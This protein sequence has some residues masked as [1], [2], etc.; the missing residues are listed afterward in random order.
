MQMLLRLLESTNLPVTYHHWEEE[1]ALP[2]IVYLASGTDNFGADNKVY[3]GITNYNVE[4]YTSKKD[5][6]SEQK[7]ENALNSNDIFWDKSEVYIEAEKMYKVT[8]SIQI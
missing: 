3:T 4:F 6:I 8:Y 2:Y 1:P 5:I 7:I